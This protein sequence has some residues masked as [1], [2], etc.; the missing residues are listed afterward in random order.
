MKKKTK[1]EK[2]GT[3]VFRTAKGILKLLQ[4]K[5]IA[6]LMLLGQGVLFLVSPS[7]D[8]KPTIRISAGL[9]IFVALI[10][11]F[12]HLRYPLKRNALDIAVAVFNGLLIPPAI[13][14]MI[15]PQ[16][17]EPFVRF[18]LGIVTIV[19]GLLNL[20]ETLK[21]KNRKDWKFIVS[22]IGAVAIMGLGIVMIAA[23][24]EDVAVAQRVI[25]GFLVL[26]GLANIWYIVQLRKQMKEKEKA[27][28]DE[29]R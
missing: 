13:F 27:H 18:A 7:G 22:V 4:N 23:Q 16:T 9:I 25:G 28:K 2:K 29:G 24:V 19:T 14:C 11:I 20:T 10:L 17:V 15:S 1:E 12:L 21:I 6:S 3:P 5:V 8:M 26:N